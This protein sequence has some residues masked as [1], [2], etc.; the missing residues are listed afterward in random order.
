M[1]SK[2]HINTSLY[3]KKINFDLYNDALKKL[4]VDHNFKSDTCK[5]KR[6][7]TWSKK[8]GYDNPMKSPVVK[9]R[10]AKN[11]KKKYRY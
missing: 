8:F 4:G 6:K 2:L 10:H 9:Q 7:K 11:F 3:N 5:E 1:F